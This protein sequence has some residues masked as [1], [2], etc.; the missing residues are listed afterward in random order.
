MDER[1]LLFKATAD[2]GGFSKAARQLHLS[3]PA[4][5]VQIRA[6]EDLY[7]AKLFDRAR[8]TTLTEAGRILYR[9]VEQCIKLHEEAM[10]AINE[11]TGAVTGSLRLGATLTIGEY[12]LPKL[13]GLF[14]KENR[15]VAYT[16][17]IA[18]TE[19]IM[20]KL[21]ANELDLGLI[22]GPV[23][24]PQLEVERFLCDELVVVLP[25]SHQWADRKAVSVDEL[26]SERLILRETGSG[27]RMVLEDRLKERGVRARV[28]VAAELGSTQAIKEAVMAG[29]GIAVISACTVRRETEA[30]LLRT[31]RVSDLALGRDL[32]IF[33]N[34]HR[35]RTRATEAFLDFLRTK[36][37]ERILDLPTLE[38]AKPY[39]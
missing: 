18:N 17:E 36:D 39:L 3:Q 19:V 30:G 20:G 16:M 2:C 4:I 34:K 26:L 11:A 23:G 10:K 27:T 32:S 14:L 38:T 22:E 29:L 5:S 1:Y 8:Q 33:Y 9:Y 24:H 28:K 35:F 37:I 31:A 15:E 13:V 6:L 21:I 12:I 25:P 7:G